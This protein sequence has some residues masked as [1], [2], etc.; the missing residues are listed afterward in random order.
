MLIIIIVCAVAQFVEFM[1][2]MY[3]T[4]QKQAILYK[5]E[6]FQNNKLSIINPTEPQR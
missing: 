1:K 6:H 2:E 3:S 5:E 4:G